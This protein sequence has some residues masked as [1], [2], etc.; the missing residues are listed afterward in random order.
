[1]EL[2]RLKIEMQSLK[3]YQNQERDNEYIRNLKIQIDES[4]QE[5]EDLAK[6]LETSKQVYGTLLTLLKIKNSELEAYKVNCPE[7]ITIYKDEEDALL[8][9]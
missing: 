5:I 7:P 3:P 6:E 1:M 9:Q 8:A 4:N 2:S